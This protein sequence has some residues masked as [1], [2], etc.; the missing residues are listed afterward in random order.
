MKSALDG[1]YANFN[2]I[3]FPQEAPLLV[4]KSQCTKAKPHR[5]FIKDKRQNGREIIKEVKKLLREKYTWIRR[6]KITSQLLDIAI[7]LIIALSY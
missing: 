1:F 2:T 3:G 5:V 6:I 4:L 7:A